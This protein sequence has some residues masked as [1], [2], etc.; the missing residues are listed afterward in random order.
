MFGLSF[1]NLA[2]NPINS[3]LP[4][5]WWDMGSATNTL[6]FYSF[7]NCG[8]TGALPAALG[9]WD[10]FADLNIRNNSLTG[11]LPPEW[12]NINYLRSFRLNDNAFNDSLPAAWCQMGNAAP[13]KLWEFSNAGLIGPLP[14]SWG[15]SIRF[16]VL[17]LNDNNLVGPLPPEWGNIP[18]INDFRLFNNNFN[19]TIPD[20]WWS[21]GSTNTNKRWLFG[22]AG[23]VGPLPAS[24][25]ASAG[26]RD[27]LFENNNI[28]GPLPPEW[29]NIPSFAVLSLNGNPINDSLPEA[30]WGFGAGNNNKRIV[31]VNCGIT[32]ALPA[33]WGNQTGFGLLDFDDNQ[34]TGPLPPEW[35]NMAQGLLNFQLSDN[36]INSSLPPEWW[37]MF[38]DPSRA[39]AITI[40]DAGLV[41]DL[42]PSWGN[43]RR[44]QRF[45]FQNNQLSGPLPPEWGNITTQAPS[46]IFLQNNDLTCHIPEA[47]AN[48]PLSVL[49]LDNNTLTVNSSG[50]SDNPVIQAW[51]AT[52]VNLLYG[53]QRPLDN[54]VV[55][56]CETRFLD[57]ATF[58]TPIFSDAGFS[59]WSQ[60]FVTQRVPETSSLTYTLYTQGIDE[61]GGCT[62]TPLANHTNFAMSELP[63]SIQDIDP[64]NTE[65]CLEARFTPRADITDAP[66]ISN[67]TASY[68]ST[69]LPS[70][71]YQV[72]VDD[73]LPANQTSIDNYATITTTSIERDG[74][75]NDAEDEIF[76]R[77]TDLAITKTVDKVSIVDV[78]NERITYT[79]E[80]EVLG[81]QAAIN[82][83][84]IDVLPPNVNF[85][86]ESE[87]NAVIDNNYLGSGRT[88][89]LWALPD[90]MPLNIGIK[91]IT[92]V[93]EESNASNGD[94]LINTV[95]IR[96]D[97]QETNYN[98]NSDDV[99]VVVASLS[100]V[101]V[102]KTG[103]SV[104]DLNEASQF[105]INYGNNGNLAAANVVI[106]D[107]FPDGITPTGGNDSNGG[108]V[109]VN[110][111]VV[112]ITL[113]TS[114][115][116]N[117]TG[118]ATID[119]TVDNDAA[120]W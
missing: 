71:T 75:N 27:F 94:N 66:V 29:G 97:R 40:N 21:I 119:F 73:R 88:A 56:A 45:D 89:L 8:L 32:G 116:T 81:P 54:A 112:T 9:N 69:E 58:A 11:P 79:L 17:T 14:G 22:D 52:Q 65:L 51:D 68:A 106:R 101:F 96:N 118:T 103:P 55:A 100:N 60:L 109:T 107:S 6:K 35:G 84:I 38:E 47:W 48:I 87:G 26:F 93:V 50:I 99:T 4:P 57:S 72:K 13:F 31:C 39:V 63:R 41:G 42:P 33:S 95:T 28:T 24:F 15:N 102:Q 19:D 34:I 59:G 23:L 120:L 110:G 30:W 43:A 12:G 108:V 82:S 67:W 16:T 111:Q 98:N 77:F 18:D 76:I 74:S 114:L 44:M 10:N 86:S 37:G 20:T 104:L 49:G 7:D 46:F 105:T 91:S 78:N 1:F 92:V 70:I 113:S 25:G 64:S 36:P 83:Q 62:G 3:P 117:T 90:S 115:G 61:T 85:V 53:T 5:E 2:L 80:Y